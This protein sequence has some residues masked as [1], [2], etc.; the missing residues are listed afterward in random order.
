M[1]SESFHAMGTTVTVTL[2]ERTQIQQVRNLFSHVEHVCSRFLSDSELTSLN[3]S[4]A[5]DVELSP[6]MAD[7]LTVAQTAR[8]L[9]GGLVDAAVGGLVEAWGYDR[10]FAEVTDLNEPPLQPPTEAEWH[11]EG[12][13]LHRSAGVKL[14]L[15]GIAKGWTADIAVQL[16]LATIVNAG[17]DLRSAHPDTIVDIDDPSGGTAASVYVG[18]GALATSSIAKRAWKVGDR[19]A[20]HIIDPRTGA[21][22]A[23][24][25][26]SASVNA[27]TAAMAEAGAKA[28]LLLGTDG[29]AW[30][31]EQ[32]W[33]RGAVCVWQDGSVYATSGIKVA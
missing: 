8:Q 22:A 31:D 20:N 9:T 12:P 25:V 15:G 32:D 13:H 18:K 29:L 3:R 21:P 5:T 30:A 4:E 33:I 28:V 7:V 2:D 14:D 6:L 16:G 26:V 23:T 19:D 1:Y 24:P 17:G 27:D 11:V 10:T